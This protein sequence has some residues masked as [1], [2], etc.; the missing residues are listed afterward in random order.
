[1]DTLLRALEERGYEVT[2]KPER[3]GGTTLV[4]V[5]GQTFDVR[6]HEPCRREIH[7]LT[8][9]EQ[10]TKKKFGSVHARSHDMVPTG[11]LSLEFRAKCGSTVLAH[12][13]DGERVWLENTLKDLLVAVLRKVGAERQAAKE[14][15]RTEAVRQEA[16]R[17]NR[18]SD[19]RQK[20][21]ALE[22]EQEE[23]QVQSLIS[24]VARWRQSQEIRAYLKEIC[25]IIDRQ[26][27]IIPT[28]SNLERWM[29]WAGDVA[30]RL[31][32]LRLADRSTHGPPPKSV[33]F[34]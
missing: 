18:R 6:L 7:L 22:R 13:R 30:Y 5:F 26:G 21:Q 1:M 28:G 12:S 15:E 27:Q 34:T 20:Q 17:H 11:R 16:K 23:A 4:T 8:T 9:D 14:R 3:I 19:E 33:V 31:D 24:E 10:Q 25:R 32:P 29:A 2:G